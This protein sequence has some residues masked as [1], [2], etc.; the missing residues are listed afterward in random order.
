MNSF[1][2]YLESKK[3]DPTQ[4]SKQEPHLYA[5]WKNSFEQM[6]PNS[7]TAQKLFQVNSIRRKFPKA[8]N[9]PS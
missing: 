1:E 8:N 5:E 2:E 6:H 4:F 9:T 3:I 7:F